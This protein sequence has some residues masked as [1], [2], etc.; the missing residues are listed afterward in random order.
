MNEIRPSL[1]ALIPLQ[2]ALVQALGEHCELSYEP[3]GPAGLDWPAMARRGVRA[4]LTN[5][6]TGLSR[7]QM[8][9]LPGLGLVCAFGAGFEAIDLA[10]AR[11]LGIA[12]TH[13]PGV[14]NATVAD[15][16]LA[17]MLALARGLAPLDRAV[18]AGL[19]QHSRA[20]RPTLHRRRLGLL[21]MGNIGQQIARRAL[22]FEMSVAYCTRQPRPELPYQHHASVLSLAAASDYLVLACPGGPATRHLV[23]R[24]VLRALGPTGFVVNVA[25]GSVLHSG[26]LIAALQA[27]EIAGAG[28][29]VLDDEPAVPAELCRL[30]QV[31]LTP[32][33]SGRS[34]EAQRAQLAC[35]LENLQAFCAGRALPNPVP[36]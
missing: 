16:A 20:E 5:G 29:D 2:P 8:Q 11:E 14:N 28:L 6:T 3:Q 26:D 12:V 30:D 35:L 15:H 18:K 36:G 27:G 32:H 1:L 17:L 22:G 23:N 25:R 33:I 24:E 31:L 4:V 19:W 10:A 21:G 34:P 13:A 7:A 9:A